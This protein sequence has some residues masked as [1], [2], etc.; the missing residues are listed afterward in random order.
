[1]NKK[2]TV[3]CV[4]L[5]DEDA[6]V[7][8]LM[9]H[10]RPVGMIPRQ[11]TER[12]FQ[13]RSDVAVRFKGVCN[14]PAYIAIPYGCYVKATAL[15]P[16]KV[17][18]LNSK[19]RQ[20]SAPN[21]VT[22]VMV[23]YDTRS[24]GD[25]LKTNML[26]H[27][28][29]P[30]LYKNAMDGRFKGSSKKITVLNTMAKYGIFFFLPLY[31]F[32]PKTKTYQNSSDFFNALII[33]EQLVKSNVIQPIQFNSQATNLSLPAVAPS[34]TEILLSLASAFGVLGTEKFAIRN[35][36]IDRPKQELYDKLRVKKTR[37]FEKQRFF[38]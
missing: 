5:D 35:I 6:Q 38:Y 30:T 20:G 23:P 25:K 19:R 27:L 21:K 11:T 15:T 26:M 4:E 29:S 31:V 14:G 28:K 37:G 22:L 36:Q 12:T 34:Q 2:L 17:R 8:E 24:I 18:D 16:S 3:F 33:I 10:I 9:A 32:S 13:K 7:E 1:M